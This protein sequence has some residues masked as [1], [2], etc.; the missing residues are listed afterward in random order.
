MLSTWGS[1]RGGGGAP[2]V[3][4]APLGFTVSVDFSLE[5]AAGVIGDAA[6]C[7]AHIAMMGNGS[8]TAQLIPGNRG[9]FG[10]QIMGNTWSG[11]SIDSEHTPGFNITNDNS[12]GNNGGGLWR[13]NA[14]GPTSIQANQN[15]SFLGSYAHPSNQAHNNVWQ[16][17]SMAAWTQAALGAK[18]GVM[19]LNGT[20]VATF[21]EPGTMGAENLGLSVAKWMLNCILVGGGNPGGA[22]M[23]VAQV[24]FHPLTDLSGLV[25]GTGT[26]AAWVPAALAKFYDSAVGMVNFGA[27]GALPLGV[28]PKVYLNVE[29]TGDPE[30]DPLTNLG[31]AGAMTRSAVSTTTNNAY[32][33]PWRATLNPGETG[34]QIYPA[35]FP[36][37]NVSAIAATGTYQ[38][39]N[40][41]GQDVQIG[42]KMVWVVNIAYVTASPN[43]FAV[44]SVNGAWSI[45][46]KTRSFG[47]SIFMTRDATVDDVTAN[48]ATMASNARPTLTWNV[49]GGNFGGVAGP[50]AYMYVFRRATPSATPLT[51]TAATPANDTTNTG[52][53]YNAPAITSV[54]AG[55]GVAVDIFCPFNWA[56]E[57]SNLGLVPAT[58]MQVLFKIPGDKSL[59]AYQGTDPWVWFKRINFGSPTTIAARN[60]TGDASAAGNQYTTFSFA[61][62]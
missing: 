55:P 54:P 44:S 62:T 33:K 30:V 20:Q 31:S 6:A 18:Q 1:G 34:T 32:R 12:T 41:Y 53:G 21:S 16:V 46:T 51:L 37:I 27:T 47:T 50:T 2:A 3:A 10:K 52:L 8:S 26:G 22:D 57:G 38:F 59:G 28:Q 42:D 15:H 4:Y 56:N 43:T 45:T 24:F 58:G 35:W 17:W 23:N 48:G 7:V 60:Y 29:P 39:E 5:L 13:G 61:L 11:A 36:A 49:N 40:N 19:A 9:M 14:S 25:T